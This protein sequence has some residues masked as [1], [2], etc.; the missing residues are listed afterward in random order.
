MSEAMDGRRQAHTDV[1][2]AVFGKIPPPP[3]A[4]NIKGYKTKKGP[5]L[6]QSRAFFISR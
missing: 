6:N 1:L 4:P 2:V 3:P 5:T